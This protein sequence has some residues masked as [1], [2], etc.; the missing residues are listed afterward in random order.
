[1]IDV[2]RHIAF[3]RAG[4][5]EDWDV[6][7]QLVAAGR[8][9]YG[10]FFAH[11]AVEKAIKAMVCRETGDLPPR[12]HHLVRLAELAALEVT[13]VQIDLLAE[14]N[15]FQIEG[16]YPDAL[17]PPPS[18]VEAQAYMKGAGELLEWLMNR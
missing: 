4:A 15:A 8:P 3:W 16:R 5:R 2:G 18:M 11:L 1:M 17:T 6:A 9:R 14:L 10:L 7:E 12:I 13:P